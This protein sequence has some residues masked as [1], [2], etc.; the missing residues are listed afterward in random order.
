[1]KPSLSPRERA[2]ALELQFLVDRIRRASNL[3]DC[4]PHLSPRLLD[5]RRMLDAP[6]PRFVDDVLEQYHR[7]RAAEDRGPQ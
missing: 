3:L 4:E 7:E 5:V 2:I 6:L 1:M